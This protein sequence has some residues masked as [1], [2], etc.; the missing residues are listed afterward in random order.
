MSDVEVNESS[1][2]EGTMRSWSP[3]YRALGL[4]RMMSS[5]VWA[6]KSGACFASVDHFGLFD[7]RHEICFFIVVPGIPF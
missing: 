3:R 2:V 6:S 7:F 4:V 1:K 5:F